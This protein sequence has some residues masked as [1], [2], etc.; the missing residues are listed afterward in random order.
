MFSGKRHGL[1]IENQERRIKREESREKNE[2]IRN[3]RQELRYEKLDFRIKN[4]DFGDLAF[5]ESFLHQKIKMKDPF[6]LREFYF[7][8]PDKKL[9]IS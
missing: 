6:M 7:N 5:K 8:P 9:S 2:E 4:Q 3:K 1:G